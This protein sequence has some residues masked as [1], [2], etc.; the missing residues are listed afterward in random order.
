M[1]GYWYITVRL[2]AAAIFLAPATVMAQQVLQDATGI[3]INARAPVAAPP[4]V[5]APTAPP[6]A[7]APSTN[8]TLRAGTTVTWRLIEEITTKK[9]AARVGQRFIMEVA[10]NVH[11]NGITVIPVGTPAWGEITHVR[12]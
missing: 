3:T 6:I 8:A 5:A 2:A 9:K 12:N 10:E 11:V 4:I 7:A 1:T